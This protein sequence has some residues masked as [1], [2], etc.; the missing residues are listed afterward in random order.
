MKLKANIF[1]T[2]LLVLNFSF[3]SAQQNEW[4]IDELLKLTSQG[5]AAI[6]GESFAKDTPYKYSKIKIGVFNFNKKQFPPVGTEVLLIPSTPYFDKWLKENKKRAKKKKEPI[7]LDENYSKCIVK[8][9]ITDN[10]GHFKFKNLMPGNYWLIT[11]FNFT[12][13]NSTTQ[14]VGYRDNYLNGRY[15]GS[16]PIEQIFRYH[17]KDKAY[18]TKLVKIAEANENIQVKLRDTESLF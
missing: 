2:L 13:T 17:T 4:D 7:L 9:K 5:S 3:L 1:T 11:E 8:T 18:P 14:V 12:H 6:S 10:K 15:I 16:A